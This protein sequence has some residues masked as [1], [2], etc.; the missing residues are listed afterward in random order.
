MIFSFRYHFVCQG[1]LSDDADGGMLSREI[2]A[3][4]DAAFSLARAREAA[5]RTSGDYALERKGKWIQ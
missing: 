2:P 5:S 1:W 3:S 4:E